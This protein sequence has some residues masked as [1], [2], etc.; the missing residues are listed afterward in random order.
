[1]KVFDANVIL[2]ALDESSEPHQAAKL[3]LETGFSGNETIG[4]A[5]AVLLAVLRIG[6]N[7]RI[8]RHP[9]SADD[10]FD[11]IDNWLALPNVV[12]VHPTDRHAR[13]LRELL[14]HAGAA[15]KH[16]TDA[17]LAALAIEHGATLVSFDYDFARFPGLKWVRPDRS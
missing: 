8:F 12:E 16:T 17:H 4:L 5:W 9:L 13:I 11:Y 10:V 6:T 14:A 1:M 2:Y 15:G 3:C 7:P